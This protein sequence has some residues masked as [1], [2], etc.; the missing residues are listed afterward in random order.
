MHMMELTIN[1]DSVIKTI[2]K[3]TFLFIVLTL[4]VFGLNTLHQTQL[5][6]L[7]EKSTLLNQKSFLVSKLHD[8][9][10][11]ISRAQFQILHASSEEEAKQKLWHLSELISEHLVNFHQL[12]NISDDSDIELLNKYRVSF[13]QWHE[14]NKDLLGYANVISDSGFINTLNKVDLAISQFDSDSDDRRLLITQLK[15]SND[16]KG[17]SN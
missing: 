5:Q 13:D 7:T 9:M 12:K 2:I 14:F 15:E 1:Q 4:C 11:L 8:Q 3:W 10:L 17:F 6:K 16:K